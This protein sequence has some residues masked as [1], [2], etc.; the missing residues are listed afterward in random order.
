MNWLEPYGPTEGPFGLPMLDTQAKALDAHLRALPDELRAL[1]RS[2]TTKA[3]TEVSPGERADVSY[4][5]TEA[6]DRDGEVVLM[7][8]MDE[9]HF[10]LNPIVTLGHNYLAPPVGQSK[11]R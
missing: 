1:G 8:G 9:S 7:S 3:T 5:T 4:I 6:I 10:R 2:V 11:W